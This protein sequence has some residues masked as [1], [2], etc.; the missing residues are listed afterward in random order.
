M[1]GCKANT[2]ATYTAD[3][4]VDITGVIQLGIN[5]EIEDR[6]AIEGGHEGL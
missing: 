5:E 1:G 2:I 4:E 6:D 3:E